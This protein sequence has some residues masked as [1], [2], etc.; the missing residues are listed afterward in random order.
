MYRQEYSEAAVEVK[1][2]VADTDSGECPPPPVFRGQRH[3][4][5]IVSDPFNYA[6]CDTAQGFGYCWAT[7]A[8]VRNR[9]FFRYYFLDAMVLYLLTQKYW[10]PIHAACVAW[11]G[12]GVL[13]CGDSGAGKSSLALACARAGWTF[14]AD[15][16]CFLIRSRRNRVVTGHPHEMR[17]RESACELFP[18]MREYLS[19]V[20]G[21]GKIGIEVSTAK[22]QGIKTSLQSPI[23]YIVFLV[24]EKT[25]TAHLTPYDKELACEWMSQVARPSEPHVR[26]AQIEGLHIL[27]EAPV[28]GLRY[29]DLESAVGLLQSLVES[30]HS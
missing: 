6:V 24:R 30:A 12:K 20:R 15:D 25:S 29:H 16:S 22:L 28:F 13:L 10:T 4:M 11:N 21:N 1:V 8:A 19:K 5:S 27:L 18:D 9:A 7:P 2:G 14:I 17:F 23:D 26:Q 3:L